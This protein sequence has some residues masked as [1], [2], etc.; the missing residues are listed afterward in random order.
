[1]DFES[2]NT[3]DLANEIFQTLSFH[4][5]VT[6][7]LKEKSLRFTNVTD[8][9]LSVKP[10]VINNLGQ[11]VIDSK[12]KVVEK[13][14]KYTVK[15][16]WLAKLNASVRSFL[17]F[18]F[19]SSLFLLLCFIPTPVPVFMATL[20]SY[21]RS[22]AVLLSCYMFILVSCFR[23][24]A[25]LSFCYMPAFVSYFESLAILLSHYISAPAI[26]AA[27][28]LLYHVFVFLL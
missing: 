19:K 12:E 4:I 7:Y 26:S 2:F 17:F 24:L 18:C 6:E 21:F 10:V 16:K 28:F 9:K 22:F 13:K 15:K 1:M 5:S 3:D 23:S 8:L 20:I 14:N 27:L 25:I 11:V